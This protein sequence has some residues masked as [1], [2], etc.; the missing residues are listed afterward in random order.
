MFDSCAFS[1]IKSGMMHTGNPR[2]RAATAF[3]ISE[4]AATK[5]FILPNYSAAVAAANHN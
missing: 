1:F 5:V 3:E 4:G 2:E